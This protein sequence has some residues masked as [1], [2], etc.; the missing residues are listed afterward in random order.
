MKKL[1]EM[2]QESTGKLSFSRVI[3]F[4]LVL[5]GVVYLFVNQD[6]KGAAILIGIGFGQKVIG[7]FGEAK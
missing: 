1:I 2:F 3:G 4:A 7:K 5:V 6:P